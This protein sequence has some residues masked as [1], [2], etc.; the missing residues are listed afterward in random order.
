M[1]EPILEEPVL[2]EFT[3]A[4][5]N[6]QLSSRHQAELYLLQ[7]H[8]DHTIAALRDIYTG[9]MSIALVVTFFGLY[10]ILSNAFKQKWGK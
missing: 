9:L 6:E 2:D 10:T 8:H 1:E 4:D 5:L 3:L 7:E